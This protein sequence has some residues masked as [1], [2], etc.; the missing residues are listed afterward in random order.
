MTG[1]LGRGR[2]RILSYPLPIPIGLDTPLQSSTDGDNIGDTIEIYDIVFGVD[3]SIID[4]MN[5]Y[6]WTLE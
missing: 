5:Y 3:V 4:I 6:P 1:L 2:K